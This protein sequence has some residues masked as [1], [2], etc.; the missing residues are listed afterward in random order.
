MHCELE[1]IIC[2]GGLSGKQH[3]YALLDERVPTGPRFDRD[4][5]LVELVRRYLSSHGP[6]TVK[7]L[8]WWSGLTMAQVRRGVELLGPQLISEETDGLT[9]WSVVSEDAPPPRP[10]GAHLLQPYDE[11]VVGFSE[12]RF[13]GDPRAALAR[14]AWKDRTVPSGIVLL[15]GR[16]AG[17]WRRSVTRAA[18]GIEAFLYGSPGPRD[19]RRLNAA[20]ADLGRFLTRGVTVDAKSL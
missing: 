4:D 15:D 3:T 17:H 10:R 11:L 6:A 1:G 7:D 12:S 16:L 9:V 8:S 13:L 18:V 19:G 5:A 20:A 14:A 2:S